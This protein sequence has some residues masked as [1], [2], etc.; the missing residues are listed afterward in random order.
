[1]LTGQESKESPTIYCVTFTPVV[2]ELEVLKNTK[3]TG[4]ETR[5]DEV[6]KL[7]VWK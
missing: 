4:L 6:G 5:V 3:K 7:E 1:M 2:R